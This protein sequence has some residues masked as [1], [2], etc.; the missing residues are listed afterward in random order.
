LNLD[1]I[2]RVPVLPGPGMTV[3]ADGVS[4]ACGGKGL[5]QAAA[6]SRS[7]PTAMI[8]AVGED[9]AGVQLID[10]LVQAGVDVGGV[11][12]F[13][14]HSTGRA[15]ISVS[16]SGENQI[17]VTS[18]ANGAIRSQDISSRLPQG[19]KVALAQ[20]ETPLAAIEAFFTADAMGYARKILNAAPAVVGGDAL[21]PLADMIIF[22]QS[23]LATYLQLDCEPQSLGALL[24]A[25]RFLTRPTQAAVVTLGAL[26]AAAIWADRTLLVE[27]FAV[28]PLDTTGAGDCLCGVLAGAIANGLGSER[29]LTLAN[30]AAALCTLTA[31]A[32]QAIPSWD[33]VEAFVAESGR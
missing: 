25:R 17:V 33:Q 5:N 29:A 4:L 22:N 20:F 12:R 18:G 8:G 7:A 21:F 9:E 30:A 26:G 1:E 24:P 19:A 32:A 28:E 10:F 31:G 16:P 11:L 3:I 13:R 14:D 6:A 15:R 23:E 27:G 2:C